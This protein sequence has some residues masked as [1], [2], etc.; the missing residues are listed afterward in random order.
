MDKNTSRPAIPI[1]NWLH[2]KGWFRPFHILSVIGQAGGVVSSHISDGQPLKKYG[3]ITLLRGIRL[4]IVSGFDRRPP[5]FFPANLFPSRAVRARHFLLAVHQNGR[6]HLDRVR[7][8]PFLRIAPVPQ[9]DFRHRIGALKVQHAVHGVSCQNWNRPPEPGK[10]PSLP[11]GRVPNVRRHHPAACGNL[12]G[13]FRLALEIG[14]E[15]IQRW[16]EGFRLRR[17][18]RGGTAGDNLA[19]FAVAKQILRLP[20]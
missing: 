6:G 15:C 4:A 13:L 18:R 20:R 11:P 7:Q 9:A 10:P 16:P 1:R 17:N 8:L 12:R 2:G 19:G 5:D 14:C 3:L